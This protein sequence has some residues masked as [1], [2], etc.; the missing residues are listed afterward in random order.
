MCEKGQRPIVSWGIQSEHWG[1][2]KKNHQQ[3]TALKRV[4]DK[5]S[6]GI[7]FLGEIQD[8]ANHRPQ[9]T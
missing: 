1:K 8:L 2:K 3:N 6:D 5:K 4:H 9:L 7:S